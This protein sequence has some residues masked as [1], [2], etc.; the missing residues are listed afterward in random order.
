MALS[1][2]LSKEMAVILGTEGATLAPALTTGN[3]TLGTGW[4]YGTSPDRIEKL[5]DGTGTVTPTA[6]TNVVAGT[7]YR[8][9]FNVASMSGS[10][11][12]WTFGGVSGTAISAAG[13]Y[14]QYIT[15]STTGK[16]IITPVA[17]GLRA[18]IDFV[19][20]KAITNE[21]LAFATDF[22]FEVNKET[23]DITTL[24]SAGWKSFLVDLKEWKVSFSGLV[25]RGVPG[26]GE[27][28]YDELMTSLIGSDT[29]FTVIIKTTTTADQYHIGQAKLMSM[30]ASGSVGD[31]LTY[32]GEMQG[33]SVLNLLLV[34]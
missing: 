32:S 3:W 2:V 6:A 7:T 15:A 31:K 5:I 4:T 11:A 34:P 8:V 1:A 13:K 21:T 20:W 24:A 26:A 12:T 29:D 9:E 17:T 19:S 18:V 27:I 25:T 30:K 10:T 16:L 22:D 33:T 23:I 28:S 14:I